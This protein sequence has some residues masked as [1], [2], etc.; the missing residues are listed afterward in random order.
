MQTLKR[1]GFLIPFFLLSFFSVYFYFLTQ[2]MP[3]EIDDV[4][5]SYFL[6]KDVSYGELIARLFAPWS[7]STYSGELYNFIYVRVTECFFY[8]DLL[9]DFMSR[10]FIYNLV[11]TLTLIFLIYRFTEKLTESR[12]G[13]LLCVLFLMTT[14]GYAWTI[15]EFG[16]STPADQ[17]LLITYLWLLLNEFLKLKGEPLYKVDGKTLLRLLLLW[18]VGMLSIRAKNTNLVVVPAV[19]GLFALFCPGMNLF[20]SRSQKRAGTFLVLI[21]GIYCLLPLFITE[22]NPPD[23]LIERFFNLKNLYYILIQNPIGWEAE[24]IPV[25][26]RFSR[27]LPTS[28]LSQ[29]GF[30][31][32]WL[33]IAAFVFSLFSWL[34]RAKEKNPDVKNHPVIGFLLFAW[35]FSAAVIYVMGGWCVFT[36]HM[37]YLL[38]PV[39]I[40]VFY[41][42]IKTAE[43]F[44]GKTKKI[45]LIL[46]TGFT[47]LQAADNTRHS[48][49]LRSEH[50]KIWGAKWAFRDA[51]FKDRMGRPP[52]RLYELQTYWIPWPPDLWDMSRY[53][54]ARSGIPDF[55]P[56]SD[57]SQLVNRYGT[58]YLAGHQELAGTPWKSTLILQTKPAHFSLL[59]RMMERLSP[60]QET[61]YLYRI[62]KPA[63][64]ISNLT[65]QKEAL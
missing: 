48:L 53:L 15:Y 42:F 1:A 21:I 59:S 23:S 57:F 9:Q 51:I 10:I 52:K 30:F 60:K 50:M 14:P 17:I 37:V 2:G 65:A 26:F 13:A 3:Y 29:F 35:I 16:D 5:P 31:L 34:R 8:K 45:L 46:L 25:L 12:L 33:F 20:S 64:P 62:E 27:Q 56:A 19:T 7:Y 43:L 63:A 6:L 40:G 32:G 36:R 38:L 55:S 11:L 61:Y 24:H 18:I 4:L 28:I 41:L 22:Q 44:S 49:Y 47:L 58:V 54:D 39:G